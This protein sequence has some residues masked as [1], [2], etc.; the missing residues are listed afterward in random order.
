MRQNPLIDSQF[1]SLML[2]TEFRILIS[3]II[4]DLIL[5]RKILYRLYLFRKVRYLSFMQSWSY[6]SAVDRIL[7]NV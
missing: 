5:V 4:V 2:N 1:L 7:F 3:Y 6:R